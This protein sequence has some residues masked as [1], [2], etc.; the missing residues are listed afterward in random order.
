M[1]QQKEK[2]RDIVSQFVVAQL[3]DEEYGV[4]ILFVESLIRMQEI[5]RVPDMPEFIEGVINLRGRIIPIMNMR[6]RFSFKQLEWDDRT[7]IIVV[8][9]EN[10]T[11]GFVV[12]GVSEVIRLASDQI[13]PIPPSI[14]NIG[15]EYLRGVG[16]VDNRLLILLDVE[17]ILNDLEGVIR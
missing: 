5:T 10:Q 2:E 4:P 1:N 15:S 7:R 11:I 14:S 12:D 13:D 16:K 6:K 8:A 17:K 3:A 9:F